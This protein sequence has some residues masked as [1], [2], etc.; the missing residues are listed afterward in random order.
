MTT[1]LGRFPFEPLHDALR[2]VLPAYTIGESSAIRTI[3]A[4][5]LQRASEALG[6]SRR[7]LYRWANGQPLTL[8]AAD[9]CA[10][11]LG[12]HPTQIWADFNEICDQLDAEAEAARQ[13][14]IA[15][16]RARARRAFAKLRAN[17]RARHLELV[18]DE[19]SA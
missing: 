8:R 18:T 7:V 13:R 14:S 5:D 17:E 11:R 4:G 6:V 15:R 16:R 12:M 1:H 9:E 2:R 10:T 3:H 19:R